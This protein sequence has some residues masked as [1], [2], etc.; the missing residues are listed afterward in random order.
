MSPGQR[1]RRV[2]GG[3]VTLNADTAAVLIGLAILGVVFLAVLVASLFGTVVGAVLVLMLV[4]A[5]ILWTAF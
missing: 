3:K 2:P 5:W 4:V 1:K